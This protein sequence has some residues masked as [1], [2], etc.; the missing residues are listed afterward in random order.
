MSMGQPSS[1]RRLAA[2]VPGRMPPAL[3]QSSFVRLW[4]GSIV[5]SIGTQM[6]NVAKLWVLYLLTH[7]AFA[8]GLEGLCF[9]VPIMVL[10]CPIGDAA[11]PASG[12]RYHHQPGWRLR[13]PDRLCACSS[14]GSRTGTPLSGLAG[15]HYGPGP[16][17]HPR[18][19]GHA[20]SAPRSDQRPQRDQPERARRGGSSGH[21]HGRR[22][23][24]GLQHYHRG[25][26]RQ[27]SS[28]GPQ[29]RAGQESSN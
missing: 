7:S 23:P 28:R 21:G 13:R 26:C 14:A 29:Q 10:P 2:T 25:R 19:A 8:L 11:D 22:E 20:R 27:R 16:H 17:R 24:G 18:P 6:S 9:S 1:L 12:P 15:P 5:S 4:A 3:R